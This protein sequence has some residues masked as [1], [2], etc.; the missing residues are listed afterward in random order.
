[1]C[2]YFFTILSTFIFTAIYAQSIT[3][4]WKG[5]LNV[6]GM[7]LPLVFHIRQEGLTLSSTMDSP[8]QGARDIKV[9]T[10][11][12]QNG[13]LSLIV[14]SIRLRY[15]GTLAGTDSIAGT[16][17][18]TNTSLPLG[19]TRS[20]DSTFE[21]N[22]PQTPRPKFNY[23][24]EDI[25]IKNQEQ[26]NLLA[27]TLTTPY[28]KKDGPVIILIT[29]SGA[30][31]R[32]ETLFGHK[33]FLVI[34][35]HFAKN[36]IATLR[37]D[38]RGVGGSEA[39]KSGATTADF[40]TDIN[41]AVN[42]LSQRGFKNIGLAGHS[43]GGM[44]AP[45]VA[46]KNKKVKFIISMAGPGV[47]IDTL[48]RKQLDETLKLAHISEAA[49]NINK[50]VAYEAYS[51]NN[52]YTGNNLQADLENDLMKKFPLTGA[53]NKAVATQISVPWFSYFLKQD[54]SVAIQQLKIPVLVLNG[55]K[56]SQVDAKQ[57]LD[58]WKASLEKAGNKNFEIEELPGLNHLFQE[59]E[60]GAVSEYATIEQTISP[61]VLKLMT[62]WIKKT[63][64]KIK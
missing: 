13:Q 38:D 31:D 17:T 41:S 30:Q 57:N 15:T 22:R 5:E 32:D 61:T 58:G 19:L 34:A 63:S 49:A 11:E 52:T 6:Q 42:Y 59:A 51:F 10:T 25:T 7:K 53:M 64:K 56:D 3:G 14:N 24:T 43:E 20:K 55:S 9:D 54:P 21:Y 8:A 23:K 40:V 62:D 50:M 4:N 18:Q 47:A 33:P 27:G 45:M 28:S 2:R 46:N 35:D 37:L 12:W 26:G 29:G 36:D 60:T 48:I 1:M 39:G 16:F 44:I